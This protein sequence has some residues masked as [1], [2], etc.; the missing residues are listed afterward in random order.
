M[1][2]SA[3][4]KIYEAKNRPLFD[5]LI[6]HISDVDQL[7]KYAQ[8]IPPVAQQLAMAFWPGPLTLLLNRKNIIPDLITSGLPD[9][10][11]RVPNHFHAQIAVKS[12]PSASI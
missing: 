9:V 6:V 3:I 12:S 5:P 8:N 11:L 4:L 10:A 1:D 2:E 7:E